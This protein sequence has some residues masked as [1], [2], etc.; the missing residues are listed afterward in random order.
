VPG[1]PQMLQL[2]PASRLEVGVYCLFAVRVQGGQPFIVGQLFEL[3]GAPATP[4][5]IDVAVTG[6]FGGA[7]DESD[8]RLLR[9][10]YLAKERYVA[11]G[12]S[13]R[14]QSG[15]ATCN[16][17]YVG[18][19]S[20][21]KNA[22]ASSD[23]RTAAADFEAAAKLNPTISEPWEWLGGIHL[24]NGQGQELSR[25]WNK[26]MA[27]GGTITTQACFERTPQSC[28]RGVLSL[29]VS[30][31]SFVANAKTIFA[32][33]PSEITP[34][35]VLN[36]DPVYI[37][38]SLQVAG[39]QYIFDFI[40][41]GVNCTFKPTLRCPPEGIAGQLILAQYVSEIL[42]RLAH[43]DLGKEP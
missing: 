16:G 43:G 14:V 25:A 31:V 42:P 9:P 15:G 40:P 17:E 3:K 12:A 23:W 26:A 24:R 20:A 7:M 4:D 35:R 39:Q 30:S 11:C 10:Y 1:Q 36:H 38:Y 27:L 29:S 22:L 41:P 33:R 37:A 18:C 8:S 2:I 13:P 32:A 6:G 34:G 28:E 21:G 19:L 5:C